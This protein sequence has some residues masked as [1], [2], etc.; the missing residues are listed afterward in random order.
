MPF[1]YK[2][3][4]LMGKRYDGM[5]EGFYVTV[6]VFEEPSVYGIAKGKISRLMISRT[7]SFGLQDGL[8]NYD[9]GWD[10][11]PPTNRQLRSI[12]EQTVWIFD[13]QNIDWS[14]E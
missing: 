13:G 11:G 7:P 10:G 14:L 5:V 4:W 1:S 2:G 6:Q 3:P 12:I 8:V 9:R